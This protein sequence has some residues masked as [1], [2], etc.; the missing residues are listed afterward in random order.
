M[1]GLKGNARKKLQKAE[2]FLEIKIFHIR[3]QLERPGATIVM[4]KAYF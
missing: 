2:K 3:G 1:L 4:G